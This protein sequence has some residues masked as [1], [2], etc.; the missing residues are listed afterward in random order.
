MMIKELIPFAKP[1]RYIQVAVGV[2]NFL[3]YLG[4]IWGM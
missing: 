3:C 2:F 4:I 1:V